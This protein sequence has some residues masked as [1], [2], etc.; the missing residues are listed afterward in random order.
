MYM[1]HLPR[2]STHGGRLKPTAHEEADTPILLYVILSIEGCTYREVDVWSHYSDVLAL[3]MD[4][5]SRGHL[6]ALT[7]A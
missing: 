2:P 6:G 4:L 5:V 3:L 7:N 1:T